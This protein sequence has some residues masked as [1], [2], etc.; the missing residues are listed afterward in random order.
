MKR[1][2]SRRKQPK[3]SSHKVQILQADVSFHGCSLL[4]VVARCSFILEYFIIVQC[5]AI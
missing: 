1:E 2:F 3:T 5:N 4:V